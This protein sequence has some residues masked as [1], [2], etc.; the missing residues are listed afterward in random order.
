MR[1]ELT[2]KKFDPEKDERPYWKSYEVEAEP[3]ERLLD[4]LNRVKWTQ[5]GTLTY[6]KS[7]GHGVCGSCAMHI[8]GE[9]KLACTTLVK[10]LKNGRVRVEA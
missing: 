10:D 8:D 2:I 6:R 5:D 9:N 4:V 1:L 3:D 7:C